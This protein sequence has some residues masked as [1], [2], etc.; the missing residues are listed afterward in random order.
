MGTLDYFLYHQCLTD[1]DPRLRSFLD[2][3][4]EENKHSAEWEEWVDYQTWESNIGHI[5][6]LLAKEDSEIIGIAL[7]DHDSHTQRF[8]LVNVYVHPLH[9]K[10]GVSTGLL[11]YLDL[12]AIARG[13][14]V[15]ESYCTQQN[16]ASKAMHRHC[17]YEL[18]KEDLTHCYYQKVLF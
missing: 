12:L 2:V 11:Q 17:G 15:I 7:A 13:V 4:F 14:R 10:K 8:S 9:R 3:F 16:V 5:L 1:A 18:I 6:T